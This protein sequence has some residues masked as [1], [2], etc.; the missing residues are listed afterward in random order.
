LLQLLP[1]VLL[2]STLIPFTPDTSATLHDQVVVPDAVTQTPVASL[3]HATCVTARS[4]EAVPPRT[5][6]VVVVVHAALDV[7]DVIAGQGGV[8]SGRL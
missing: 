5:I 6:G 8:E 3:K 7:G 4:P 1:V 2:A